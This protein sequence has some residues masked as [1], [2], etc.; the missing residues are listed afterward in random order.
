[1]PYLRIRKVT[2]KQR[3]KFE[4]IIG[5]NYEVSKAWQV[6]EN[7][8]DLFSS[9]KLFA[10]TLYNKWTTDSKRKNIKEIDKVIETFNNHISGVINA[11][12]MNLSN[13]MAERLNGKIQ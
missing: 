12:I 11:L 2:E 1:M 13:A 6:R 8:K 3:I 9:G 5:A 7:F 4:S 10:W